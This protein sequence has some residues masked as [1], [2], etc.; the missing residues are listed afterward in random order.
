MTRRP[1]R[2]EASTDLSV[3]SGLRAAWRAHSDEMLGYAC[4]VLGDRHAAEE[5]L[6]EAFLRAWRSAD[7]YDPSRPLRPWLFA[8]LR[9]T[10]VD[11]LRSR[12]QRATPSVDLRETEPGSG[13]TD[14]F[15]TDLD[16]WLVEEALRRIRAEHAAV[17]VETYFRGRTYADVAGDLGIPEGTARSR[18]FYGLRA[19]RIALEEMGWEG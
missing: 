11:E 17:I 9:N 10:V 12:P 16:G 8:I 5:A 19:L 14:P 13:W 2:Q 18:V 1:T 4:R 3:D 7:R 15:G 6:Q